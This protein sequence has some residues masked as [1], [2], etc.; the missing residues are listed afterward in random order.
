MAWYGAGITFNR[1]IDGVFKDVINDPDNITC[2]DNGNGAIMD[3]SKQIPQLPRKL[4]M[5]TGNIS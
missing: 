5:A 2:S 1:L 4:R 3:K